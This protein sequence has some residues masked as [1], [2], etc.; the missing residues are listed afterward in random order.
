MKLPVVARRALARHVAAAVERLDPARCHQE[1]AYVTALF[2]RL[3]AM[4][5]S[6]PN[7]TLEIKSTVVSDRGPNSA[8]SVWGADF[9][10]VASIR[11]DHE[12]VDKAIL[13]Q[14]KRG[15]L[16]TLTQSERER[17][18]QQVVK[19]AG[20]THATVGLEVPT[21]SGLP[22]KVRVV[23]VSEAFGQRWAAQS[24]FSQRHY[25]TTIFSKDF[26]EPPVLLGPALSLDT[27]IYS[28][29]IRCLHGDQDSRLIQGLTHSSLPALRIEARSVT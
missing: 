29:L 15:S 14:A 9:G 11:S 6:G 20:A 22:P 27:Y 7:L 8:E 24:V 18:R 3:D 4:V 19:M 21:E 12:T 1:P 5:Y 13:G 23:E 16:A 10:I 28:E 17:F 26:I 2:A 25:E